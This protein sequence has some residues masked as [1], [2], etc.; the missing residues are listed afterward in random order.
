MAF[1]AMAL[2][3][4]LTKEG[5]VAIGLACTFAG[6]CRPRR[7][8]RHLRDR[9]STRVGNRR[10]ADVHLENEYTDDARRYDD[11]THLGGPR[12]ASRLQRDGYGSLISQG[13]VRTAC[14]T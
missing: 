11:R 10:L 9:T 6:R 12:S 8:P 3:R 13:V 7:H 4:V 2:L 5:A 1:H 14:Y